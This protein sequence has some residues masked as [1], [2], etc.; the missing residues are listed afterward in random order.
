MTVKIH[1]FVHLKFY[2]YAIKYNATFDSNTNFNNLIF[3]RESDDFLKRRK[4]V[5]QVNFIDL[6]TVII[7]YVV[8]CN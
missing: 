8:I 4:G 6:V 2:W 1:A 3:C 7:D 5:D